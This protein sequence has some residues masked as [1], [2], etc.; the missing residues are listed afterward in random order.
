MI[1]TTKTTQKYTLE[2]LYGVLMTHE[3]NKAE[4]KVKTLKNKEVVEDK[5]KRQIALKSIA[6]GN[7]QK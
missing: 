7:K 4:T 5:P 2:E 1:G 3:L 6:E